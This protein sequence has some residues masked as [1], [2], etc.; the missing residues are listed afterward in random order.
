MERFVS[1]LGVAGHIRTADFQGKPMVVVPVVALTEGVIH[2]IN[3]PTP[4]FVPLSTLATAPQGWNGRPVMLGHPVKD[5]RQISANDPKVLESQSLGTVFNAR[6][7]GPKLLM[8]CYIDADKAKRL[9]A[10]RLLERIRAG[11]IVNVSVGAF[12]TTRDTPGGSHNGKPY[13][14]EWVSMSPDHLALLPDSVGACSVAA[15]CGTRAAEGRPVAVSESTVRESIAEHIQGY[16]TIVTSTPDP[17]ASVTSQ[18]PQRPCPYDSADYA[19]KGNPPDP[20]AV[21]IGRLQKEK[22]K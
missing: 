1:L 12:V 3:A 17:Y 7:K 16:G 6:I 8:D 4:E 5:G 21:G 13:A 14:A 19:P 15:G 9:G 2:A 20:Y 10:D 11:E 18:V 22:T